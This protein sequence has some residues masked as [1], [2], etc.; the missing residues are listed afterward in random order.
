MAFVTK[1]VTKRP[2]EYGN[3]DRKRSLCFW[4][5]DQLPKHDYHESITCC[6]AQ[7]VF[8]FHRAS[9]TV[10]MVTSK[11]NT[12]HPVYICGQRHSWTASEL[13]QLS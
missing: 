3:E 5:I 13:G 9:D 8:V 10:L 1:F 12:L 6:I 11:F 4:I 2:S 7:S